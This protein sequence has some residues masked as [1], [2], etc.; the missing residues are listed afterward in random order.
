MELFGQ[1]ND[2]AALPPGKQASVPNEWDFENT[3]LCIRL[4]VQDT[5]R[6]HRQVDWPSLFSVGLLFTWWSAFSLAV[7]NKLAEKTLCYSN[8]RR[9]REHIVTKPFWSFIVIYEFY[10]ASGYSDQVY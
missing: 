6:S 1:L 5:F 3:L 9:L 4:N 7:S 2:P 10:I 8:N